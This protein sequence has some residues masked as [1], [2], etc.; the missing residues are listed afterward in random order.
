MKGGFS[1]KWPRIIIR[2]VSVKINALVGTKKVAY[3]EGGS[4]LMSITEPGAGFTKL[5]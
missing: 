5:S 2:C 3:S 4:L 1:G